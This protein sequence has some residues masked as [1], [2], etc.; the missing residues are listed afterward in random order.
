M[1]RQLTLSGEPAPAPAAKPKRKGTPRKKTARTAKPPAA[2][3]APPALPVSQKPEHLQQRAAGIVHL[4]RTSIPPANALIAGALRRGVDSS[5]PAIDLVLVHAHGSDGLNMARGWLSIFAVHKRHDRGPIWEERYYMIRLGDATPLR[6]RVVPWSWS[7][8]A[9]VLATG[10][11]GFLEEWRAG[12][13]ARGLDVD[14]HGRIT[15]RAGTEISAHSEALALQLGGL[16]P[17][18]PAWRF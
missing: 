9:L 16:R 11:A 13:A 4:I 10:P 17:C 1:S 5:R 15:N 18:L 2:R 12:L 7:G 3:L 14:S 8:G 6:V